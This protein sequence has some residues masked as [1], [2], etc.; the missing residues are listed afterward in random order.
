MGHDPSHRCPPLV[1][2]EGTLPNCSCTILLLFSEQL[3]SHTVSYLGP[4]TAHQEYSQ[5]QGLLPLCSVFWVSL[6]TETGPANSGDCSWRQEEGTDSS[7][8]FCP[9]RVTETPPLALLFTELF[10][11]TIYSSAA[12]QHHALVLQMT[13]SITLFVLTFLPPFPERALNCHIQKPQGWSL[14][15]WAAIPAGIQCP[16]R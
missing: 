8:S 2:A 4:D 11:N 5:R 9:C 7:S 16:H 3:W 12:R 1:T 15:A 6:F 14:T 13:S 10:Q